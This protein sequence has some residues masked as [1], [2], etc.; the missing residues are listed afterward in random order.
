[1]K[2]VVFDLDGTLI[3]S[4]PDIHAACEKMLLQEGRRPLPLETVRSFIGNGVPKLVERVIEASGLAG[5]E[6]P[7][8]TADFLSHY[9]AAPSALTTVYPGARSLLRELKARGYGVGLCTNKPEAPT[10]AIL[11]DLDLE[12]YFDAIVGGDTLQRRKPDPAP[13]L[14]VFEQLG[15]TGRLYVGDS[16]VDAETAQRANLPFAL[17][18]PGYRRVAAG[19]L[20]HAHAFDDFSQLSGDVDRLLASEVSA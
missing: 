13:L 7:R 20:P 18:L 15:A 11:R 8:L 3:D 6:L 14:R 4:A 10:R 2:T 1:M 19:D 17:Y 5:E 16:E 12:R 9:E